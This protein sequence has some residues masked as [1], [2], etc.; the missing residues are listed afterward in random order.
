M[1]LTQADIQ[2]IREWFEDNLGYVQRVDK[3][4]KMRKTKV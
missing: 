2:D 4:I 1:K 3:K